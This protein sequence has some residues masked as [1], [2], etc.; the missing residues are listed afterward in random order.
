MQLSPIE[1]AAAAAFSAVLA[2]FVRR[3]LDLG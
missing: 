2:V 1:I 3:A